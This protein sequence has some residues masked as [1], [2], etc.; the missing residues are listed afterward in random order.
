MYIYFIYIIK[1]QMDKE[2]NFFWYQKFETTQ[3][4]S[5]TISN[6]T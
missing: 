6:K 5:S 4:Q 2:E 1:T 3:W